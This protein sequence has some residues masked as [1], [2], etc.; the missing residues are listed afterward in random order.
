MNWNNKKY[1]IKQNSEEVNCIS[2]ILPN[3]WPM[4]SCGTI[5]YATY[6]NIVRASTFFQSLLRSYFGYIR[7]FP[8][9]SLVQRYFGI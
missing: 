1:I 6:C 9:L 7:L 2:H 8:Y 3:V 5:T 4:L